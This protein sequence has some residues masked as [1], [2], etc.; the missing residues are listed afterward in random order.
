MLGTTT[1]A[2]PADMGLNLDNESYQ[3]VFVCPIYIA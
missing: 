3:A 1:P 2:A